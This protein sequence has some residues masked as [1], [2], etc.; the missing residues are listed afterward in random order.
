M[1]SKKTASMFFSIAWIGACTLVASSVWAAQG[2]LMFAGRMVNAGCDAHV[3]SAGQSQG[4]L[5][6]LQTGARVMV[7]LTRYDD[8]CGQSAVPVMASYVES[9]SIQRS[10]HTGIVTLTYQ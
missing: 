2:D 3:L 4:Q 7:G 5:K 1:N 8:A 10:A 6:T 9:A